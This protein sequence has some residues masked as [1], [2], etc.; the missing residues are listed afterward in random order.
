MV[1]SQARKVRIASGPSNS[2][3]FLLLVLAYKLDK[4]KKRNLYDD[5]Q[6]GIVLNMIEHVLKIENLKF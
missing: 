3:F 1:E 4:K 5:Y 6:K 2:T